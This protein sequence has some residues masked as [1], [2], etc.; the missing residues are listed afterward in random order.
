MT[1]KPRR[2]TL[3]FGKTVDFQ[4]RNTYI[5]TV[6]WRSRFKEEYASAHDVRIAVHAWMMYGKTF[7]AAE[8]SG[9]MRT[10]STMR[11]C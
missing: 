1:D 8:I 4:S 2:Q 9:A 3:V 6:R 5:S 10:T 11:R 7:F